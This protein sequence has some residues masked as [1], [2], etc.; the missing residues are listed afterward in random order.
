VVA[1]APQPGIWLPALPCLCLFHPRSMKQR[2]GN[3]VAA[4]TG[5]EPLIYVVDDEPM[6]LEMAT[7]IL[8]P[9][10]YAVRTFRDPAQALQAFTTAKPEP[11]LVITD[12]A[13]HSMNGMDLLEGCRRVRP[14]Q[15]I[16]L[17]SGTVDEH[18]YANSPWKPDRFLAK[19]YQA[20]Q[21]SDLVESLLGD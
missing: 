10:G 8:E 9:L 20:K 17:V 13:M 2:K 3:N 4:R 7:V 5:G 6:L 18:I 14:K 19:P 11:A 16:I 12:Y 1:Q 15:K 21:L